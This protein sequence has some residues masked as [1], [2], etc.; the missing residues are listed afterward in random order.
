MQH[1]FRCLCY[2]QKKNSTY[3][4]EWLLEFSYWSSSTHIFFGASSCM[5]YCSCVIAAL[6]LIWLCSACFEAFGA[7]QICE[8]WCAEGG[9]WLQH[10][11]LLHPGP[12]RWSPQSQGRMGLLPTATVSQQHPASVEALNERKSLALWGCGRTIKWIRLLV[13][14][15]SIFFHIGWEEW[16]TNWRWSMHLRMHSWCFKIK[17]HAFCQEEW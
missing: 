10:P 9:R 16:R 12:Y 1:V 3:Y 14:M 7:V 4:G 6:T 17:H 8:G 2:R 11:V 5:I 15:V 13:S